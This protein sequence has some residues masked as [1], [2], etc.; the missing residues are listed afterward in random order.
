MRDEAGLPVI[1]FA[2]LLEKRK[3][4]TGELDGVLNLMC[5][6]VKKKESR[7]GLRG[8]A[9]ADPDPLP[10]V[11]AARRLLLQSRKLAKQSSYICSCKPR[12]CRDT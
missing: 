3:T 6:A 7:E 11:A 4:S 12:K 1:A 8:C 2:R 10:L 9:T 5:P